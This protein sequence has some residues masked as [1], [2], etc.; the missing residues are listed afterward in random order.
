MVCNLWPHAYKSKY[1]RLRRRF[2]SRNIFINKII[3]D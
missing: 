2:A 3:I 1:E